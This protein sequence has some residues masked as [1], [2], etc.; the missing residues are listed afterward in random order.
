LDAGT[1]GGKAGRK[2][3][4][5]MNRAT[6]MMAAGLLGAAARAGI[7]IP[8]DGSDG[9][10]YVTNNTCIDLAQAVTGLWNDNNSANAGK[11]IYDSNRWAVVFKYTNVYVAAGA[12]VTFSNHPNRAPVVW[13]VSGDATIDGTVSVNGQD[14][15]NTPALAEPGPG[16]FR[17]GM[18][19]YSDSATPSAGFGPGGG[20]LRA[21]GSFGTTGAGNAGL[22]PP[23][24]NPSLLPLIGGS[25]GGGDEFNTSSGRG[26]GAGGGAILIACARQ[27]SV[28]GAV[29]SRGGNGMSE[30]YGSR[31]SGGSGGG[32]RLVSE[33]LDG[34]GT[35]DASGGAGAEGGASGGAGRI[36]IERVSYAGT[37]AVVPEPSVLQ[38]DPGATPLIWPATNAPTVRI[39]SI[40]GQAMPADPRAAFGGAGPDVAIPETNLTTVVLVTTNVEEAATVIVRVTPR[41][42]TDYTTVSATVD[43]VLSTDPLVIRWKANVPVGVGASAVQVRVVRP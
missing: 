32:L 28:N 39:V 9:Q 3:K 42:N 11:G 26:G 10:L 35:L 20:G 29:T 25:G 17:G 2:E 36:R 13:L 40:G 22:A 18:A 24:G 41:A 16:G 5:E 38:L 23:Y 8:S 33:T 21:G 14:C 15:V 1:V 7:N 19:R 4:G 27:L 31:T 43:A 30:H 6:V 37:H 12:T 34:S